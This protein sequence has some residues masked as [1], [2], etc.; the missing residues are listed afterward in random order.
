MER[1]LYIWSIRHPASSYVQGMNDLL[2]P[3]LL[4]A[5]YPYAQDVLRCDVAT[6]NPQVR[7]LFLSLCC[8]LSIFTIFTYF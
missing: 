1:V 8:C 3:L 4:V 2:C 7:L 5:M 6:L